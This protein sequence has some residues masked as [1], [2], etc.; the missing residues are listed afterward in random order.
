VVL[1]ETDDKVS[2]ITLNRPEKLNAISPE[3]M[4][5][6]LDAFRVQSLKRRS[7]SFGAAALSA[8]VCVR[9]AR[10]RAAA[11]HAP[12]LVPLGFDPHGNSIRWFASV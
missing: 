11:K 9:L 7:A 10:R 4:R 6:L 8:S 12:T 2:V 5:Q 1:Y 3:L